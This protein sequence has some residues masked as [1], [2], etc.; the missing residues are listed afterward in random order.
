MEL[1]FRCPECERTGRTPLTP[2]TSQLEC[3]HCQANWPVPDDAVSDGMVQQCV[4]C[5]SRDLFVRK[6]FPQR[7]GVLMVV[8]GAL[9]SCYAWYRHQI[10]LAFGIL[11]TTAAMD[12]LL[13][14]LVRDALV[15]YRCGAH[16]RGFGEG[17]ERKAFNLE[18]HER[19]R[20]EAARQSQIA[21]AA[22]R[23]REVTDQNPRQDGNPPLR[24]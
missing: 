16:Y 1:A 17:A 24:T 19:Y 7:L 2:E 18:T 4:V 8:I 22:A 12:V 9:A 15:C 23:Q 20:Q 14:L 13:Y 5:R 10:F 3:D 6:D 11:F 21:Q